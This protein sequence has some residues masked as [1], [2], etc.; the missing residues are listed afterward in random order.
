[1][2]D[3]ITTGSVFDEIEDDPGVA[4][5][6]KIKAELMSYLRQYIK[7]NNLTQEQAAQMMGVH[8]PRVGDLSRG[9]ISVFTI[10]A[11]VGMA[12]RVGLHPVK[13]VA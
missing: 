9:H 10:D 2:A 11:L 7:D 5:Q 13:L 3:N 1:M 8:R 6:L 4:E 12:A